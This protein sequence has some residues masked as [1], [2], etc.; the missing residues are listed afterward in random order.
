MVHRGNAGYGNKAEQSRRLA[1][2]G[3]AGCLAYSEFHV[4]MMFIVIVTGKL[5]RRGARQF[6][7]HGFGCNEEARHRGRAL[8]CCAHHLGRV[9]DALRHQIPVLA[10]LGIVAIGVVFL[11]EDFGD[12]DRA[13]YPSIDRDL[14]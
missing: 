12:D 5:G 9:D 14:P 10:R 7:H 4:V 11:F 2:R 1:W 6:G 8:E 3:A 13:V